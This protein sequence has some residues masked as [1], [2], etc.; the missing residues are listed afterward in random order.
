[1][2]WLPSRAA[3][4]R[5]AQHTVHNAHSVFLQGKARQWTDRHASACTCGL[6]ATWNRKAA[7]SITWV[8][9]RSFHLIVA[10][11]KGSFIPLSIVNAAQPNKK[12]G[13]RCN[14]IFTVRVTCSVDFHCTVALQFF[15]FFPLEILCSHTRH[16]WISWIFERKV[17]RIGP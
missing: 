3:G 7:N 17:V 13:S 12:S 9:G 10:V 2:R 14:Y 4:T 6:P 8:S 1:M 5:P 15:P 16:Y 11:W